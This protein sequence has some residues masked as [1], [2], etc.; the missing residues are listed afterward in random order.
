MKR[1]QTFRRGFTL[2]EALATIVVISILGSISSTVIYT[3][4]IAYR[5]AAA[6]GHLHAEVSIA[7]EVIART[8]REVPAE[9]GSRP[10]VP[11]IA[12]VMPSS[13]AWGPG[14]ASTLALNGS[15]LQLVQGGSTVVLLTD[16][17]A[18]NIRCLNATGAPLPS[19]ISGAGTRDIQRV[20]VTIAVSRQGVTERL[21]TL[22][23]LRCLLSG[24]A[25]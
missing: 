14:G 1:R 12:A 5:D 3:G 4:V 10:A 22:V 9:P 2:V 8:L 23:F 7:M 18:F 21:R 15:Q 11:Q 13:I 20:E 17:T 6:Q 25:P 16:V 24:A 19:S